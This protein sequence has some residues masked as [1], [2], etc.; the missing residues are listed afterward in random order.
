M[1]IIPYTYN[2]TNFCDFKKGTVVNLEFDVLGKYV[3]K[4][5]DLNLLTK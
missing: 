3:A 2:H 4:L 5:I 1:A